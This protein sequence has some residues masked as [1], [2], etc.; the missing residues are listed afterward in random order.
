MMHGHGL[1][2]QPIYGDILGK[3]MGDNL[4][5]GLIWVG[6]KTGH[7]PPKYGISSICM[8]YMG[9][10][11]FKWELSAVKTR[12]FIQTLQPVF[13]GTGCKPVYVHP[14]LGHQKLN[15]FHGRHGELTKLC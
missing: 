6:L 2:E 10:D 4:P 9:L 15:R 5:D 7:L 11:P 3:Q 14:V 1:V 13:K 12:D 8:G